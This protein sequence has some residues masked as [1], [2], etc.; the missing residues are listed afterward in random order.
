MSDIQYSNGFVRSHELNHHYGDKVHIFSNPFS[1]TLLE[2]LSSK[3]TFQ[4]DINFLVENLYRY[5]LFQVMGHAFPYEMVSSATRMSEF[6]DKGIYEGISLN[7]KTPIV[8]VNLARAGTFPSHIFYSQLNYYFEPSGIRQDHFYC[9]RK[10]ND[11]DQVVGVDVSGSKIGGGIDNAIVIFPDPMG[12][13]GGTLAEAITHYKEQVPGKALKFIAVHLIITPE[14]IKKMKT[15]HPDV[16]IYALR[17]DRGLSAEDVL[18]SVPGERWDE[19]VGLNE[20]QYI[21]PGAG[22]VG[23]ILNNSFV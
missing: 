11:K 10:V 12:A 3:N 7:K 16:E 8:T 17:L 9:N 18:L 22:G 2:R 19:E 15:A 23:E 13:T 1:L 6:T 14:Y 20:K 5:L 4:P 21:V